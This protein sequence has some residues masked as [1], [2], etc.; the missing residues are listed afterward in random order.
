M[1]N[2]QAWTQE[3]KDA[4]VARLAA[5]G[6]QGRCPMCGK[7]SFVLMDGYFNTQVIN[8]VLPGVPSPSSNM[9]TIAVICSNCGFISHHAI[10]ALDLFSV[11]GKAA[12][13]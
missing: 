9:P 12:H 3:Q 6:F 8:H 5:R 1:G 11:F 10:G 13:R 2:W 4:I 7:N